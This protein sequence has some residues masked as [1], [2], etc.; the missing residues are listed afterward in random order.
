MNTYD[1]KIDFD[2]AS[3]AWKCNKK[4]MGNGTYKYICSAVSKT[5]CPCKRVIYKTT[6]MCWNHRNYKIKNENES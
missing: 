1:I 6:N 4:Y 5:N 2:G 3:K